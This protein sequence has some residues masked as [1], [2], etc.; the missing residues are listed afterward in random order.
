MHRPPNSLLA[1]R[2]AGSGSRSKYFVHNKLRSLTNF[3][4][5]MNINI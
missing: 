4:L 3:S 5:K 1:T 2:R